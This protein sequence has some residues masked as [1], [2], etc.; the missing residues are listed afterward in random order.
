M[1]FR[2]DWN[3]GGFWRVM[4]SGGTVLGQFQTVHIEVPARLELESENHG[5][6]VATGQLETEGD[7]AWIR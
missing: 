2:V 7:E 1:E 3:A 6:L 5:W 4:D